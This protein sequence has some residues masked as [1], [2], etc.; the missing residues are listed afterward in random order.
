MSEEQ[1]SPEEEIIPFM[2]FHSFR[3]THRELLKRRRELEKGNETAV[4]WDDAYEFLERGEAAGQF[5]D[6]D[7]DR[8][9]AQNL[10]DY[11][12]NQLFHAGKDIPEA[13][14]REFDP[15]LQPEI[16]DNRCP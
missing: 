15:Y 2:S 9:A 4:F 7:E 11:W 12:Q 1:F 5:L 10:L 13:I 8:D 14:L 6:V 16:P 3:D